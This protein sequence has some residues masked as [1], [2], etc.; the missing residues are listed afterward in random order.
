MFFWQGKTIHLRDEGTGTVLPK[1]HPK[2]SRRIHE[3]TDGWDFN[4][5]GSRFESQAA[6]DF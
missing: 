3:C 2:G 4:E 1:G 5:L 6:L